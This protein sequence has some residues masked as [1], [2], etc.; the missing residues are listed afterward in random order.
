LR[1]LERQISRTEYNARYKS[2]AA[3]APNRHARAS[4]TFSALS[5]FPFL[6]TRAP[7]RI[8][9]LATRH[10]AA[11]P[12]L[13]IGLP[14]RPPVPERDVLRR[15]GFRLTLGTYESPKEAARAYD[16]AAWC[17]SRPQR[18]MNFPKMES[19]A[20]AEFLATQ[21]ALVT[22]ED[23]RRH[24]AVQRRLAIAE[25]DECSMAEWRRLFP[26]DVQAEVEFYAAKRAERRAARADCRRRKA[27]IMAQINGPQTIPDDDPR[28]DDMWTDSDKT[29]TNDEE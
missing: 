12:P 4:G 8:L 6:A 26:Q 9:F 3:L 24:R 22:E 27:F 25:R 23:C 18:E 10:H 5:L 2:R 17:V 1:Y 20:E 19:L 14:R 16:V 21:P 13:R 28:W 11:S 29:T 15:A 7:H